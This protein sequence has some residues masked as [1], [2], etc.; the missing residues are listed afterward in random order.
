MNIGV[1]SDTHVGAMGITR[2]SD[3]LVKGLIHNEKINKLYVI[4]S[5]H[6]KMYQSSDILHEIFIKLP[7]MPYRLEYRQLFLLP[8]ILAKLNVDVV[9]DTYHFGP[10]FFS[11]RGH[12]K[13][14]TVHDISPF[15]FRKKEPAYYKR[16]LLSSYEI[17]FRYKIVFRKILNNTDAIIAISNHTKEDLIKHFDISPDKIYVIYQGVN[18]AVFKP[19]GRQKVKIVEQKFYEGKPSIIL[20]LDSDRN[21]DNVETLIQSFL[22]VKPLINNIKLML[23]G[24]PNPA[25]LSLVEKLGVEKDVLFTGYIP[26]EEL[27]LIYNLADVFVHLSLYEGFG[28]SP[29]EAMACGTP[30]IVSN[31][32]SLP[33]VVGDA[34]ILVNP[35][36][37]RCI[38]QKILEVITND[39]LKKEMR[40][41]GLKRCNDFT[42]RNTINSTVQLYEDVLEG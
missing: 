9:H 4:T 3:Q 39:S 27:P 42:W 26:E 29:L 22:L 20:G 7:A 6:K 31:R 38:G 19:H 35:N 10:F 11:K 37:A 16:R 36:D 18:N 28:L 21:I 33:E 40:N 41:K 8:R 17:W 1:I 13:I 23:I 14:I 25:H 2:Y 32:T 34:G 30:V 24:I 12:S 15:I 5:K